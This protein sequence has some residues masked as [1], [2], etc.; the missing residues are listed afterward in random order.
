MATFCCLELCIIDFQQVN[1]LNGG[2]M[3]AMIVEMMSS[4]VEMECPRQK[5]R[6]FT[7]GRSA[8]GPHS[9]LYVVLN[10]YLGACI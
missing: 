7:I 5:W 3:A 1:D 9:N 8:A 6:R 10:L 2:V 4:D